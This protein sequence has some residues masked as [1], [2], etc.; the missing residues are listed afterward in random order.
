MGKLLFVVDKGWSA[1]EPTSECEIDRAG[2]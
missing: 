2:D 1:T